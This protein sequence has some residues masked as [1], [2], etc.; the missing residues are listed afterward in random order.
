MQGQVV[1]GRKKYTIKDFETALKSVIS[2]ED[3]IVVIISGLWAI[4][5]SLD[6]SLKSAAQE[7]L[8]SILKVVTDKRT[9]VMPAY[10]WQFCSEGIF[11][12]NNTP[13][14]SGVLTELFRQMD[15]V[16]RTHNP[17]Y[18]HS[19]MGPRAAE[20]LAIKN[21]TAWADD[22]EF[23]WF[24]K[25]NARIVK[26]GT[27]SWENLAYL[28]RV[29]EMA[30]V[31]YRFYKTF[32]GTY[33][34][35]NTSQK[36]EETLYVRYLE[37]EIA[38]VWDLRE[39]EMYRQNVVMKS[40]APTLKIESALALDIHRIGMELLQ[41]DPYCFIKNKEMVKNWINSR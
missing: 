23:G 7:I 25:V 38:N 13:S 31:P 3:E 37:V 20:I 11:D 9:L 26:I 19:V 17:I 10:N 29:E 24:D 14:T 40:D 21:N 28:H 8:D 35:G 16:Q 6:I 36:I 5:P 34:N 12:L 41:K 39:E 1:N 22:S 33:H 4:L 30:R 2:P 27:G 18:S 15:G 32:Q